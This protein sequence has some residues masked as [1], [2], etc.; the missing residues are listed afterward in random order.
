MPYTSAI[1]GTVADGTLL[2]AATIAL[3]VE[4]L[5]KVEQKAH[6]VGE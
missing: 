1:G 2:A 3:V 5:H 4:R 6:S